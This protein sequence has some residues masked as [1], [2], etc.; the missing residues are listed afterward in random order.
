MIDKHHQLDIISKDGYT[1]MDQQPNKVA[2]I[3]T[4]IFESGAIVKTKLKVIWIVSVLHNGYV[5][6]DGSLYYQVRPRN[7]T[8]FAV[9]S[10]AEVKIID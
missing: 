10:P 6:G 4:N 8:N 9:L 7:K 5:N 2:H 1:K 3:L